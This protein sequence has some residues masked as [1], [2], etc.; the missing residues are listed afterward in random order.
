[1]MSIIIKA[2]LLYFLYL[3]GR[4]LWRGYKIY[5]AM[6]EAIKQGGASAGHA[7]SGRSSYQRAR[8]S[9]QNSDDIIEAEYRV[10]DSDKKNH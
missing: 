7:G 2:L 4:G 6:Q 10:V 8:P 1:M 5:G 3:I 9:A